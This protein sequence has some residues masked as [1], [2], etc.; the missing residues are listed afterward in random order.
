MSVTPTR[1]RRSPA[2]IRLVRASGLGWVENLVLDREAATAVLG[3]DGENAAHQELLEVCQAEA[4]EA[5]VGPAPGCADHLRQ[6]G[7]G[8]WL[9]ELN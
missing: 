1:L 5:A 3:R 6:W 9:T 4:A 8:K 2:G 7:S